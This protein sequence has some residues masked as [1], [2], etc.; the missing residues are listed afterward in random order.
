MQTTALNTS[1]HCL[2]QTRCPFRYRECLHQ[3]A[4]QCCPASCNPCVMEQPPC[5]TCH[6]TRARHVGCCCDH[7]WHSSALAQQTW[8]HLDLLGWISATHPG[9]ASCGWRGRC[10][11]FLSPARTWH[12]SQMCPSAFRSLMGKRVPNICRQQDPQFNISLPWT[13]TEST[14]EQSVLRVS[15]GH[16]GLGLCW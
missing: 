1:I 10:H 13:S 11:E 9:C 2:K 6:V 8:P 16:E 3:L 7:P 5:P 15:H 4:E 14:G 12:C